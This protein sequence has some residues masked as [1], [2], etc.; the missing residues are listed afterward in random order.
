MDVEAIINKIAHDARRQKS[1]IK[2][3]TVDKIMESFP[4]NGDNVNKLLGY[5]E[6]ELAAGY[7]FGYQLAEHDRHQEIFLVKTLLRHV[8]QD[9]RVTDERSFSV[10]IVKGSGKCG[11]PILDFLTKIKL[12][13]DT[14]EAYHKKDVGVS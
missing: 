7:S 3:G 13:Y 12:A 11:V 10:S 2:S 14:I 6:P 5:V 4:G 9:L 8:T 1:Q